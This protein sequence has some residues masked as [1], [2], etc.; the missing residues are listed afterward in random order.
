VGVRAVMAVGVD[1][2]SSARILELAAEITYPK[3]YAALGIH[4]GNIQEK[5]IEQTIDFIRAHLPQAHAV[6]EIGLDFWYQWVKKDEAKKHVQKDVFRRQLE[7]AKEFNL[8]V[9]VHSRGAWRTCF[10]M[11]KEI[12]VSQGVFHW[13]S[14]PLDVLAEILD[15][16]FY[17]SATPSLAYSPE[18]QNAVRQ[19]PVERILVETDTPVYYKLDGPEPL[20]HPLRPKEMAQGPANCG[21]GNARGPK[22]ANC[23]SG[24]KAGPKDVL[25]TVAL[26]AKIK[27][28]SFEQTAGIVN[29]SAQKLFQLKD[30]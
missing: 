8:P 7:L 1:L 27:D 12:G 11:V 3:I 21:S 26:L 17:I 29:L 25:R 14:G 20:A 24:F 9:I 18:A 16:G 19:A 4:P 5:Q 2:K 10:E 22:G 15:M 28:L 30:E 23:Q 6:G 13:Y